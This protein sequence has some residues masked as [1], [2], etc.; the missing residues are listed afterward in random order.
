MS[1][2]GFVIVVTLAIII[3]IVVVTILLLVVVV[4]G[5][6]VVGGAWW[7]VAIRVWRLVAGPWVLTVEPTPRTKLGGLCRKRNREPL[8]QRGRA[9]FSSNG[10]TTGVAAQRWHLWCV[11][12]ADEL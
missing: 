3:V 9:I 4:I 10:H 2:D 11:D 8:L 1:V 6:A 12:D 5:V 7:L